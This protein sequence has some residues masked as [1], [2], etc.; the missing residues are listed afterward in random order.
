MGGAGCGDGGDKDDGDEG[1]GGVGGGHGGKHRASERAGK[2]P[3]N[4]Q[5]RRNAGTRDPNLNPALKLL[6][7]VPVRGRAEGESRGQAGHRKSPG[8]GR[9]AQEGE[10]RAQGAEGSRPTQREGGDRTKGAHRGR[11]GGAQPQGFGSP[12]GD[13]IGPS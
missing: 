8:A 10:K 4:M 9:K 6:R 1:Q 5:G 12:P 11:R 7:I 2:V 3:C 13:R